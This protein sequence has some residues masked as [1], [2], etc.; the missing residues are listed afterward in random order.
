MNI[1][2]IEDNIEIS[3]LAGG[4]LLGHNITVAPT[5]FNARICLLKDP[6]HESFDAVILDLDMAR[7]DLPKNLQDK[8]GFPGYIFY[9]NILKNYDKLYKNTIFLTG[10]DM[11]IKKQLP[12]VFNTLNVVSKDDNDT[13]KAL[14]DYLKDMKM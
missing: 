10:F 8:E 9:E 3:N 6:G 12:D 13:V 14:L 5:L 4:L 7:K 2:F 11:I 1:L